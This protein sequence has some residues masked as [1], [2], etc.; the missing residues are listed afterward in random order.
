MAT[1][2]HPREKIMTEDNTKIILVEIKTILDRIISHEFPKTEKSFVDH[3]GRLRMLEKSQTKIDM[4]FNKM[5][6]IEKHL[7]SS[8]DLFDKRIKPIQSEIRDLKK[9]IEQMK[10]FYLKAS[11]ALVLLAFTIPLA[12]RF[13]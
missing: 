12:I 5:D 13:I 3:E 2:G 8:D 11:G 6:A 9:E 4:M 10:S 1:Q 7:S